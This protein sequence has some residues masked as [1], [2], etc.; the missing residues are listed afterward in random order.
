M[1]NIP[2]VFCILLLLFSTLIKADEL[3]PEK[4]KLIDALMDQ[5]GQSSR[6]MGLQLSELY[7]QSMT[8]LYKQ[9]N[10]NVNPL[11]YDI[12]ADEI[13]TTIDEEFVQKDVMAEIMY[14]LYD[15]HFTQ[16]ELQ[17]LVEFYQTDLGK[18]VTRVMPMITKEALTAGQKIGAGLGKIVQERFEQRLKAEG[19]E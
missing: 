7:I 3:L 1:K 8:Q 13:K 6:V 11:V 10:P 4:K 19:I 18:K 9:N 15:Q 14:P 16:E 2:L 12:L 5:S 17:T